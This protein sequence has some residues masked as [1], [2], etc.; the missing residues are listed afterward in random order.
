MVTTDCAFEFDRQTGAKV[1]EQPARLIVDDKYLKTKD[2]MENGSRK[3][4]QV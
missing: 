1:A 4:Y 3:F 2:G